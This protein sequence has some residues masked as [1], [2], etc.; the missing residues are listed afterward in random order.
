MKP[1]YN[2]TFKVE[3][4]G[5]GEDETS[6]WNHAVGMLS[7]EPGPVPDSY[8]RESIVD[9]VL[10]LECGICGFQDDVRESDMGEWMP[11]VYIGEVHLGMC[12][13]KCFQRYCYLD[14]EHSVACV[15]LDTVDFY[16]HGLAPLKNKI[17][18][19]LE[20]EVSND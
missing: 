14:E 12:C 11:E 5:I 17:M 16:Q 15:D 1:L 9:D 10:H 19:I 3:L 20:K 6:A 7:D 4:A 18:G 8:T 2:Y 13:P